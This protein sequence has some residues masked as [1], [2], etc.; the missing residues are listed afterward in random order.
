MI[1]VTY[2]LWLVTLGASAGGLLPTTNVVLPLD[3]LV[4]L[5]LSW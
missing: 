1:S 4:A 2:N 5:L 3:V